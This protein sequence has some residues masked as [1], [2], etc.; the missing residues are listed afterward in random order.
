VSSRKLKFEEKPDPVLASDRGREVEAVSVANMNKLLSSLFT[1][2]N[3][4]EHG[5]KHK[6][7][8]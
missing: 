4:C 1:S 6:V 3:K 2:R 7:A 8:R 5:G